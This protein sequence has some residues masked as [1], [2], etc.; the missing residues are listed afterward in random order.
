MCIT[1]FRPLQGSSFLETPKCLR[2]KHCIVNVKN[3]DNKCFM[4]AVLSAIHPPPHNPD[5]LSNY[6]AYKNEL[7]FGDLKFPITTRN[8]KVP[9]FEELNPNV[10]VNIL[11]FGNTHRETSV[12]RQPQNISYRPITDKSRGHAVTRISAFVEKCQAVCL[13]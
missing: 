2:G 10:S 12:S 5:R 11:V 9:K 8:V 1:R 6:V 7:K 4:W 3:Q 13:Q